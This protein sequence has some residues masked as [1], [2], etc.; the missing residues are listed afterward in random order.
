MLPLPPRTE[1]AP[2]AA[3]FAAA[4]AG[5][6]VGE[7]HAAA[8][9]QILQGNVPSWARHLTPVRL[10]GSAGRATIYVA[11]DYSTIGSDADNL[12]MPLTLPAAI[13]LCRETDCWLPTPRSPWPWTAAARSRYPSTKS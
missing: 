4:T 9:E 2:G 6:A 13:A 8:V 5:L 12:R 10:Q 1:S 11:S 3:A 7:R